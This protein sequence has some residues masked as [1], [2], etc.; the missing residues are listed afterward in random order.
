MDTPSTAD[1]DRLPL[2]SLVFAG[3]IALAG[4]IA[5]VV[6]GDRPADPHIAAG[7][8]PPWWSRQATFAAAAKAGD[9]VAAGAA[10]FIL[11]VRSGQDDASVRL[12]RAGALFSIDPGRAAPCGS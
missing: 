3:L 7:V 5:A 8:F 11:V 6:L 4:V 1:N 12:R 9:V 10:P 2:P